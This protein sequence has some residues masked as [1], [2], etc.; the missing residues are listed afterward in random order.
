MS[1]C[2]L[3]LQVIANNPVAVADCFQ[4]HLDAFQTVFYGWPPGAHQQ[5]DPTC[6]FGPVRGFFFK[7]ETSGRGGLHAHSPVCC[8]HLQPAALRA[9][10]AGQ[11]QHAGPPPVVLFMESIM[12]QW[13]PHP[14]HS[15]SEDPQRAVA[16]VDGNTAPENAV[17]R[18]PARPMAAACNLERCS[19]WPQAQQLRFSALAALENNMH[20][21]TATCAKGGGDTSDEHCRMVFPRP[22]Q[23]ATTLVPG[24]DG[25]LL[26][27]MCLMLVPYMGALMLAQPCNHAVYL[28]CEFSRCGAPARCSTGARQLT[29]T[30]NPCHLTPPGAT[31]CR[32]RV[33][34]QLL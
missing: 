33:R 10:F 15:P 27:R 4:L 26:K 19:H 25:V 6:L 11:E 21:H 31:C 24:S 9:F 3:L 32:G 22:L 30:T 8:P 16:A 1:S 20:S 34:L 7:T 17:A 18:D 23:A 5:Q 28:M 12:R 13:L 14:L 2:P 29:C